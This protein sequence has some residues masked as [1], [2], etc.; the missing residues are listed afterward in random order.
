M[1]EALELKYVQNICTY[2]PIKLLY[3]ERIHRPTA[4]FSLHLKRT[5]IIVCSGILFVV[6]KCPSQS[7]F[8]LGTIEKDPTSDSLIDMTVLLIRHIRR[9]SNDSS[10]Q[11]EFCVWLDFLTYFLNILQSFCTFLVGPLDT[12]FFPDR[13]SFLPWLDFHVRPRKLL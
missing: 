6:E 7:E 13:N 3:S 1:L 8:L 4:S 2:M 11:K 9:I 5:L 10:G 12:S